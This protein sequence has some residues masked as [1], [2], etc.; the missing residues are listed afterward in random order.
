MII[1]PIIID[2]F[3]KFALEK[4]LEEIKNQFKKLKKEKK[5]DKD[6]LMIN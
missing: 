2:F 6:V 5:D 3:K 1:N 4:I